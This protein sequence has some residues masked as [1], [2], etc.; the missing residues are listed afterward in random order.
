MVMRASGLS[1]NKDMLRLTNHHRY[2]V[3]SD[4]LLEEAPPVAAPLLPVYSFQAPQGAG[5]F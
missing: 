1:V 4:T 5:L 2:T 3:S